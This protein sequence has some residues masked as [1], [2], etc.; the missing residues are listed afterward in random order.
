MVHLTNLIEMCM[1][2]GRCE[3][4]TKKKVKTAPK[5]WFFTLDDWLGICYIERVTDGV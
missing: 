3:I 1:M 5:K 2:G 4:R